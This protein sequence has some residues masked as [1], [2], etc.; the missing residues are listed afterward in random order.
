[1]VQILHEKPDPYTG[2]TWA[3]VSRADAHA[4]PK[5]RLGLALYGIAGFLLLSG[6]FKLVTLW[7]AGALTALGAGALPMLVGLGLLARIPWSLVLAVV[8]AG[9][10]LYTTFRAY[11]ADGAFIDGATGLLFLFDA[12]ASVAIL[13]HLLEGDR[14]NLIYRHRFRK[15]SDLTEPDPE[16]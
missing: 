6:L 10:T 13:F 15:Y 8:M 14:P 2:L 7:P 9:F 12:L 1:M 4:H 5:G 11:N 16:E 3:Y